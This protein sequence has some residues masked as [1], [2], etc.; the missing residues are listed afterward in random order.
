MDIF[1]A[2]EVGALIEQ[3]CT[4]LVTEHILYG[5]FQDLWLHKSL[6]DGLLQ[7]LIVC[8]EGEIDIITAINGSSRFLYHIIKVRQLV[9]GCI[10]AHHHTIEADIVTQDILENFTVGYTFCTM[11]GMIARHHTSAASQTNHRL[12]GEQY[13]FHHFLLFCITTA[14]IAEIVL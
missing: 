13:L 3:S 1:F 12:M 2:I 4:E 6:V 11:Y 7:V 14:T 9:D 10:V 8:T 5:T